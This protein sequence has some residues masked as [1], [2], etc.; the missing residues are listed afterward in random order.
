MSKTIDIEIFDINSAKL[1]EL[2]LAMVMQLSAE[3]ITIKELIANRV[4]AEVAR[5]N[6]GE[7]FA[8]LVQPTESEIK[9]NNSA[10]KIDVEKQIDIALKAFE[11]NQFFLL[12]DDEQVTEL[13][14][15]IELTENTHIAFYRLT[16]VVGG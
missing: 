8:G 5:Y 7:I 9:L 15:E 16:P 3:P 2:N 1:T 12:I 4:R 13:D 10:N 11:R 14:K 6:G